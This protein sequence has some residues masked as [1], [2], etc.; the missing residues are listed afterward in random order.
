M[1]VES[2]L[3]VAEAMRYYHRMTKRTEQA[4]EKKAVA[5]YRAT[6]ATQAVIQRAAA[7][8]HLKPSV[9]VGRVAEE[10]ARRDIEE[11]ERTAARKRLGRLLDAMRERPAKL[12]EDEAADLG[13]EAV[14]ATRKEP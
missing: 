6:R 2:R 8:A 12:T 11:A 3:V 7:L 9:Y 1:L 14:S 4:A 10:H 5:T 13:R